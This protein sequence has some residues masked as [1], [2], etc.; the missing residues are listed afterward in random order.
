MS[1]W[2]TRKNAPRDWLHTQEW[3]PI[4]T[5]HLPSVAQKRIL[6]LSEAIRSY[7]A[8]ESVGDYLNQNGITRMAFLRAFNRCLA[9]DVQGRQWGWRGLL[10]GLRVRP[11]RRR[12]P[13]VKSGR[14]GRGGFSG[15]M[16]QL[17]DSHRPLQA[18]FDQYLLNSAKRQP[19]FESRIR[20][21]SAHL[22][23]V[24]LCRDAGMSGDQWPFNTDKLGRGAVRSYV[25][26]FIQA[27]YDDIVATQYGGR[28]KAK[29]NTGTG[30]SSR[31]SAMRTLDIVELDEHKCH[32]VG[33]IGIPT[34]EGIRWLSMQRISLIMAVDRAYGT[35][36]AYKAIFRREADS[37]DVLEVLDAATGKHRVHPYASGMRPVARGG[38]PSSLG[39]P[40]TWCGFNQLLVDNALIH[41]ARPVLGRARDLIG[42]DINYG[43]VRRFERRPVVEGVFS[44]LEVAGFHRLPSTTGKGP[45]DPL[46]Q[47]AEGAAIKTR[48]TLN[49]A[50]DLIE[51]VVADHNGKQ[52]KRN[53]GHSPLQRLQSLLDDDDGLGMLFPELPPLPVG[54]PDLGTAVEP[55]TIHGDQAR[56]VRPHVYFEEEEYLGRELAQAWGLIGRQVLAHVD[57]S[58]IRSLRLVSEVGVLV[59]I[60][61]VRGRWR[62]SP[63]SRDIRRHINKL[64]R[65]GYL[66]VE[67]DQDPVVAHLSVI[68]ERLGRRRKKADHGLQHNLSSLAE[69]QRIR[70]GSAGVT[71]A[72]CLDQVLEQS[73]TPEPDLADD[74]DWVLDGLTALNGVSP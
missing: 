43:P 53:F 30:T 71:A 24:Q 67:Y 25:E 60:V 11:P 74:A 15:A 72:Q 6:A 44:A 57:R 55:L 29:S 8:G 4:S 52:G 28:A 37:E 48:L 45:H 62:H 13:L 20:H 38:Y 56:G 34:P 63:H 51:A 69:E 16:Q 59:D 68:S 70:A 22:K 64:I 2:Y 36:L 40:F 73:R 49:E 21:R 66:R 32:F 35:V 9:F 10:P 26:R 39:I 61:T 33:S 18:E 1:G 41:L 31:L 17:L 5:D 14:S 54:V 50:L 47:D 46:R 42:F 7:V 12:K 27:R 58:D 65:D 3:A 23:F 19:G